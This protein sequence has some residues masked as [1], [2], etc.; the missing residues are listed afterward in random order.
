MPIMPDPQFQLRALG[1]KDAVR[2]LLWFHDFLSW[3]NVAGQRS[4]FGLTQVAGTP[5]SYNNGEGGWA[6]FNAA[7][8]RLRAINSSMRA[9][10][11]LKAVASCQF[12]VSAA[13][14]LGGTANTDLVNSVL[15]GIATNAAYL[16]NQLGTLSFETSDASFVIQTTSLGA[17]PAQADEWEIST[18][19][20]GVSW[21]CYKNRVLVAS[22][23][24][25]VPTTTTPMK[26]EAGSNAATEFLID[27]TYGEADMRRF[28]GP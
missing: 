14:V 3:N 27:W 11:N 24:T 1:E 6:R 12:G 15:S 28:S 10:Q 21:Q 9:S 5:E 25:R 22:H 17:A 8:E 20:A 7:T 2:Q 18:I 16:L 26:F 23:A 13:M 19:N 4:S